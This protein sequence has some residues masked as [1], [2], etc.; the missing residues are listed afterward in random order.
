LFPFISSFFGVV[1]AWAS[2]GEGGRAAQR[3]ESLLQQMYELFRS[4]KYETLRPTTGI[5]NAVIKGTH[6][7]ILPIN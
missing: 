6:L 1:D 2:S 4:G 7:L 5:F 3:A